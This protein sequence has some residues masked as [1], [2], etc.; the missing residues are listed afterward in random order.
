MK[1]E[2]GKERDQIDSWVQEGSK[3]GLDQELGLAQ[4]GPSVQDLLPRG[5]RLLDQTF[6]LLPRC[7]S[8]LPQ[9]PCPLLHHSDL[10][11]P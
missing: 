5:V 9:P 6:P 8:L 10:A 7:S 1:V 3:V 4:L 11:N 2:V